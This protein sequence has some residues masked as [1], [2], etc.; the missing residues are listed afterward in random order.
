MKLLVLTA[1]YPRLDGTH[2]R[3]YVHVRNLYYAKKGYDVIVLNFAS[4]IDYTID[5]LKVISLEMDIPVR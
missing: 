2:E 4:K 1:D 5:S 3:M